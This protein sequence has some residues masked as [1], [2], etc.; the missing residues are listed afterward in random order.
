[1]PLELEQ[2]S[3]RLHPP[4]PAILKSSSEKT[5]IPILIP[6]K[7]KK[8]LRNY[9][10]HNGFQSPYLHGLNEQIY[11]ILVI[12]SFRDIQSHN[13]L[14]AF[15]AP[16]QKHCDI[17]ATSF[18]CPLKFRHGGNA[19]PFTTVDNR[20]TCAVWSFQYSAW[21]LPASMGNLTNDK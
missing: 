13:V 15:P 1:M 7:P 19:S 14:L 12:R 9:D 21:R 11:L 20:M 4:P 18:T 16:F 3:Q 2:Y 5:F 6:S 17:C 8:I 10:H